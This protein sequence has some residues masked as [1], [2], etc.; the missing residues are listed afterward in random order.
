M[1]SADLI[2]P[3]AFFLAIGWIFC[4]P[5]TFVVAIIHQMVSWF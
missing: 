1:D 2:H 5:P 3:I 4:A